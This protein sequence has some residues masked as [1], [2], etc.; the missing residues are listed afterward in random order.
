MLLGQQSGDVGANALLGS[1][2]GFLD[3]LRRVCRTSGLTDAQTETVLE[4]TQA[5]IA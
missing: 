5:R 4:R 2:G 1:V 3:E